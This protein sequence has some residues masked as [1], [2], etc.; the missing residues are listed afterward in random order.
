MTTAAG[1]GFILGSVF[2]PGEFEHRE[3]ELERAQSEA[4]AARGKRVFEDVI[5]VLTEVFDEILLGVAERFGIDIGIIL[6]HYDLAE[7]AET[8]VHTAL[9][10]EV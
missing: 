2:F 8:G 9:F 10:G 1:L 6:D 3:A 5:F 4:V 7:E